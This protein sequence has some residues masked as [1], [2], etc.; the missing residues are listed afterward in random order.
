MAESD[1]TQLV[2]VIV[3]NHNRAGLLRECLDSLA[4]QTYPCLEDL[5][6][7]N[8]STDESRDLVARYPDSRVRAH[9]NGENGSPVKGKTFGLWGLS[10]KPQAETSTIPLK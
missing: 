2:S 7:D 6:V 8:G 3:V 9:E 1:R 4:A 10:F 5:V